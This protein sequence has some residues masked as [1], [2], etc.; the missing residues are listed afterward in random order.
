MTAETSRSDDEGSVRT[1]L[2]NAIVGLFKK[3]YGRGPSAARAW[4]LDEY[5]FV[6]L[7][8]GLTRGEETLLHSGKE[9]EIRKFRLEYED[10]VAEEAKQLVADITGR[11]VL[12]YHSQIVF[13][14]VR[15]FEIFVLE[16]QGSP[17]T[18]SG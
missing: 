11:H 13:H 2:E 4:V 3:H 7:E 12:D 15:S 9:D 1:A 17:E 14:P 6:A 18:D 8:E 5:V 16:R 10:A